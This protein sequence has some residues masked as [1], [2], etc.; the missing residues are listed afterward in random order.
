MPDDQPSIHDVVKQDV[1]GRTHRDE[2]IQVGE[3]NPDG[4]HGMF[5]AEGG[6]CFQVEALAAQDVSD[7]VTE[8]AKR[9]RDQGHIE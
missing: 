5:L 8:R 2:W 1:E 6:R 9:E 7:G 4:E 3:S